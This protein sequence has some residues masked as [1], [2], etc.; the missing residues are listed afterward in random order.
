MFQD[1][2]ELVQ[3]QEDEERLLSFI[4]TGV[5]K[6]KIGSRGDNGDMYTR[7]EL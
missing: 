4:E 5:P 1:I 7:D 3:R 2:I 6:K